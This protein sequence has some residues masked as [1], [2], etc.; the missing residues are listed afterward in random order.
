VGVD[1]GIANRENPCFGPNG[2]GGAAT[3]ELY[4]GSRLA[5]GANQPSV[6][7]YVNT[8]DPGNTYN[9]QPIADWPKPGA[10]VPNLSNPYGRC[11]ADSSRPSLGANSTACAW[12]YGADIASLDAG[13][14][15]PLT[16][17]APSSFLTSASNALRAQG[18]SVSGAASSYRWWLDVET[19]NTWQSSTADGGA[20]LAMN[21]AVLEG[22]LQYLGSLGAGYVGIYSTSGQWQTITGGQ[23]AIE[24]HWT[25]AGHSSPSPLHAVPDWV[26][27]ASKQSGARSNCSLAPFTGGSIALA[28]WVQSSLD[29]DQA[30]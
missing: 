15:A 8:A 2:G 30:C 20:G 26:P 7:L 29:Y 18:A 19:A 12:V 1:D 5:G 23:S 13:S 11:G 28:Q 14:G 27:G 10:T 6:A 24:N 9:G 25:A 22:M 3:S 21:A 17:T 4:W 16:G